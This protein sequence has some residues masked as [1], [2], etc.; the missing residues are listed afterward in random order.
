MRVNE[1]L[2]CREKGTFQQHAIVGI[3]D[4]QAQVRKKSWRVDH[5]RE[6]QTRQILEAT[7]SLLNASGDF[8]NT[9]SISDY[10]HRTTESSS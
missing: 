7:V 5:V 3:C 8:L 4:V 2:L 1:C 9:M 6:T 10:S